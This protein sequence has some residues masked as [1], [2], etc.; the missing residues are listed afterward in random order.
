DLGLR[1]PVRIAITTDQKDPDHY[2]VSISQSG[3]GMPDRDY[4]LKD[5]A[6][7]AALRVQ[8]AAHIARL[9]TL[10]GERDPAADAQSI[11]D[12]ETRIAK[13]HWPAARRRERD[14]TYNPRTRVELEQLAAGVPLHVM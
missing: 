10:A 5:D 14:L 6:V 3:L 8:Y 2:V 4:Y 1:L 11:L 9:L 12:L 13:L 7:S